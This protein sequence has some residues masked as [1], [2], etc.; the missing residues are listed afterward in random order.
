MTKEPVSFRTGH[1]G[2]DVEAAARRSRDLDL[3]D[4]RGAVGDGRAD[5]N[6]REVK[7]PVAQLK[8]RVYGEIAVFVG[9]VGPEDHNEVTSGERPVEEGTGGGLVLVAPQVIGAVGYDKKTAGF[10]WEALLPDDPGDIVGDDNNSISL[11][12]GLR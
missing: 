5:E 9:V 4:A 1:V 6:Q 2:D 11:R 8:P 12:D 7:T 3:V 10:D